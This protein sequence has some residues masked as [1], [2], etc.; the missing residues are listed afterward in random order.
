[1]TAAQP[2]PSRSPSNKSWSRTPSSPDGPKDVPAA[3]RVGAPAHKRLLKRAQKWCLNDFTCCYCAS[4]TQPTKLF[5]YVSQRSFFIPPKQ[6]TH[7]PFQSH[8]FIR[9]PQ[10]MDFHVRYAT[11]YGAETSHAGWDPVWTADYTDGCINIR[12][13]GRCAH[14]PSICRS[15]AAAGGSQTSAK[16]CQ[17]SQKP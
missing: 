9:E 6:R 15:V 12:P 7:D 8:I 4:A 17:R 10:M 14:L 13:A 11:P 1:M 16:T 5:R 3:V 2:P